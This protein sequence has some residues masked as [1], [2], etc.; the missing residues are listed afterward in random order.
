MR[1]PA[2]SPIVCALLSACSAAGGPPPS[3]APRLAETIDPRVPVVY[4]HAPETP[5]DADL[6]G[7]LAD[8]VGR[9]LNGDA[10]FDAAAKQAEALVGSAGSPQSESW[11]AAQEALTHAV[12][13]RGPTARALGDI[14]ALAATAIAAGAALVPANLA[15]IQSASAKVGAIDDRQTA[16]V[17]AMQKRLGS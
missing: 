2:L 11:I 12:A 5:V 3:L 1:R 7:K 17:D 6:A 13:E 10:A 8:L 15:A 14:D 16:R 9:A 4:P